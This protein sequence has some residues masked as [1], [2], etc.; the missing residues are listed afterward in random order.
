MRAPLGG[1]LWRVAFVPEGR[2]SLLEALHRFAVDDLLL[3]S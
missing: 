3:E 2:N 1:V